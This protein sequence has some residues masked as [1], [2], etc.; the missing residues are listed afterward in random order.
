MS[1]VGGFFGFLLVG[2]VC[3]IGLMVADEMGYIG[4][5]DDP[6][7]KTIKQALERTGDKLSI[8]GDKIIDAIQAQFIE[9]KRLNRYEQY[10]DQ[11]KTQNDDLRELSRKI[12]AK[13]CQPSQKDC[14]AFYLTQYVANEI[15]Y[16]SD[17]RG[18]TDDISPWDK[19]YE[20]KHGDCEDQTIL[21]AS[22][23][24]NTGMNTL[25]FFTPG[26]VYPGVC[27]DRP[28]DRAYLADPFMYWRIHFRGKEQMCLPLE[29]TVHNSKLGHAPRE[30][31]C[32]RA[33]YDPHTKEPVR[34]QLKECI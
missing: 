26:H 4:D 23:L 20:R 13:R 34:I 10:M 18:E 15:E 3:F 19:T 24:E 16:T 32:F 8:A 12:I 33:V 22:L 30:G 9:P 25:M 21:L 17:S 31:A 6:P 14:M 2:V 29:P 1:N 7:A 27:L 5:D 28:P 11:V